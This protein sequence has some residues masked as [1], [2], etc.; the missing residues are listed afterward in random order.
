VEEEEQE[1]IPRTMEMVPQEIEGAKALE[2]DEAPRNDRTILNMSKN[3]ETIVSAGIVT[4]WTLGNA[5][6]AIEGTMQAIE[7]FNIGSYVMG[8]FLQL[9]A[10]VCAVLAVAP[11]ASYYV[12]ERKAK[13]EQA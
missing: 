9:F 8:G 1:R 2:E 13:H 5:Y 4:G 3:L 7:K 11:Y 6:C 10:S 12:T